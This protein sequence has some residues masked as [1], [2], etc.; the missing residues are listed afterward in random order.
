MT[1]KSAISA[2]S[3]SHAP[4]YRNGVSEATIVACPWMW[5]L[6]NPSDRRRSYY[7]LMRPCW[8]S[9]SRISLL[10]SSWQASLSRSCGKRVQALNLVHR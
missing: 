1:L 5:R 7:L 3:P 8:L 9:D 2:I 4:A 10:A 6:R